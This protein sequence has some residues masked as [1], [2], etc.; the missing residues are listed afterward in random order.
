MDPNATLRQLRA[1]IGHGDMK[2]AD[3]LFT[4]LDEWLYKGGFLPRAWDR[5]KV[6][7]DKPI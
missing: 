7:T 3:R 5:V 6:R 4:A 1:A 2:E